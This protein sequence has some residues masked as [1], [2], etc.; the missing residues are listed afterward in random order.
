MPNLSFPKYYQINDH[1]S[2][3]CSL[4]LSHQQPTFS[5]SLFPPSLLCL[6]PYSV[7]YYTCLPS[8]LAFS[9]LHSRCTWANADG[10]KSFW[11]SYFGPT[12]LSIYSGSLLPSFTFH[13]LFQLAWLPRFSTIE[14]SYPMSLHRK[15]ITGKDIVPIHGK[16]YRIH[17]LHPF[18]MINITAPSFVIRKYPDRF[19]KGPSD[20]LPSCRR[21]FDVSH[22]SNMV[23]VNI[24]GSVHLPDIEGIQV[25]VF[26]TN[27]DVDG[28]DRIKR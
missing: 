16:S 17:N 15:L 28:L 25:R 26:T 9:S 19:I 5:P 12:S 27:C 20:K 22:S 7:S 11:F 23:F 10:V 24:F 8:S 2:F 4:S 21:I 14:Y 18:W 1:I 13:L 3:I 6:L